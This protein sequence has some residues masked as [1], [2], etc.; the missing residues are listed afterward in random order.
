M[1]SAT[2]LKVNIIPNHDFFMLMKSSDAHCVSVY[3][4]TS[5]DGNTVKNGQQQLVL[6]NRLKVLRSDLREYGL[7]EQQA[8]EYLE[9]IEQLIEDHSF[10]RHQSEG[11]AL[12]L[13][14]RGLVAYQLPLQPEEFAYVSDH[15]YLLPLMPLLTGNGT[16]YILALNQQEVKLFEANRYSLTEQDISDLAPEKLED[17]VG[18]DFHQKSL[19][20]RTGQGGEAG[21]IFH[22]HGS[23]KDVRG[24]EV[25]KFIR[26]VDK[27]LM[28]FLRDKSEPLLLACDDQYYPVYKK[29][30]D[31]PYL[32][33]RHIR[34]NPGDA[35]PE[36]LHE[37]A[38][39]LI[40]EYFQTEKK[41]KIKETQDLSATGKT[42]PDLD[43][44]IIAAID[45]RIDTLFVRKGNDRFGLYDMVNRSLII[46]REMK[47]Y[48][49]SLYNMAAV[50]TLLAGGHVFVVDKE[51][52]PIKGTGINALFRY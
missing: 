25:E 31:Y 51:D 48:H 34:S 32:F 24:R 46:D 19:Q 20:F 9:P 22:G 40:E 7:E 21:A 42:S 35:K 44:I 28:Q 33:N 1:K 23:A 41:E 30:T 4:P 13:N 50:H 29:I 3:I 18:S 11:L 10:W 45:G 17:A 43:E 5:P 49:A 37:K 6:K 47:P 39:M 16:F 38:W 36:E 15:F 14:S 52:M 12:F 26:A 27:G 2:N 8:R